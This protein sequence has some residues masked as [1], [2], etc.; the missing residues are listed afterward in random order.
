MLR[1]YQR[2]KIV[3]GLFLAF[4]LV[5]NSSAAGARSVD[6][7]G[8][9]FANV[10]TMIKFIGMGDLSSTEEAGKRA[11]SSLEKAIDGEKDSGKKGKLRDALSEVKS[12]AEHARKGEWPYAENAA[13]RALKAIE[14]VK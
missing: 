9:S 6:D 11:V 10:G 13:K 4:M 14:E 3:S 12:A 8:D 5:A 2:I 1:K 7:I